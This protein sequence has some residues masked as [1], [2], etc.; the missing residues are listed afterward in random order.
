MVCGIDLKPEHLTTVL[1]RDAVQRFGMITHMASQVAE[2]KNS[3]SHLL[4]DED[5]F[6]GKS[7][8]LSQDPLGDKLKEPRA[9]EED[10]KQD[11]QKEDISS[12]ET[13]PEASAS[14]TLR[15][16]LHSPL[17]TPL[18]I[19]KGSQENLRDGKLTS[20]SSGPSETQW[21]QSATAGKDTNRFFQKDHVFTEN[22]FPKA[23]FST[24]LTQSEIL[25]TVPKFPQ[26]SDDFSNET[27][28]APQLSSATQNLSEL[29]SLEITWK[30][31]KGTALLAKS[32]TPFKYLAEM[33]QKEINSLRSGRDS[34]Q[35]SIS[36]THQHSSKTEKLAKPLLLK[37]LRENANWIETSAHFGETGPIDKPDGSKDLLKHKSIKTTKRNSQKNPSSTQSNSSIASKDLDDPQSNSVRDSSK[38]RLQNRKLEA[39]SHIENHFWRLVGAASPQEL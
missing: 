8:T 35:Q 4:Q 36:Q 10:T 28:Q 14:A 19:E 5:L 2:E 32:T 11:L 17:E 38:E 23:A 12:K 30:K 29:S 1:G 37:T 22:P 15:K 39:C 6:D 21:T 18:T 26:S 34:L 3:A 25:D 20:P 16:T 33:P 24:A 31:V 27:G 13:F 9:S 7:T